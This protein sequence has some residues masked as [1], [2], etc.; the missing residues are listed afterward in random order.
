MDINERLSNIEAKLDILMQ[1]ILP[2]EKPKILLS[3]YL[4]I[5]LNEFRKNVAAGTLYKDSTNIKYQI[6]PSLGNYF[7]TDLSPLVLQKYINSI[8]APRQRK[9]L[10]TLLK[11]ALR[12][13]TELGY[14]DTNPMLSVIIPEHV[15]VPTEILSKIHI[16]RF[17]QLAESTIYY[18]AFY[19]LTY[20]GFR[21]SELLALD[22]SNLLENSIY[23]T[24]SWNSKDKVLSKTKTK[25]S[26]RKV[27]YFENVKEL[28]FSLPC[29]DRL[30]PYQLRHLEDAFAD[31][32]NTRDFLNDYVPRGRLTLY[33]L[34]HT[35]IT[36][37]AE[38]GVHPKVAMKWAG[39][40][41][42]TTT[43]HYYTHISSDWEQLEVQKASLKTTKKVSSNNAQ[44]S[45]AGDR[46]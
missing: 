12:K 31:I 37:W 20:Q 43:L 29:E 26:V 8:K 32:V 14:I 5:W 33:S 40:N 21:P 10:F 6:V 46:T 11:N 35:C 25:N 16:E 28:L 15:S 34:R 17:L 7:L 36:R 19:T 41:N 30:F 1:H 45:G 18:I 27:P 13:A 42:I 39:H 23:I 9:H 2:T 44:H 3:D 38:N 22:K 24:N 4:N